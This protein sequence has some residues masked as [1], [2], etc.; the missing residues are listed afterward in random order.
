MKPV[1]VLSM[2]STNIKRLSKKCIC[3]FV[4]E[5]GKIKISFRDYIM[6]YASAS[7]CFTRY[8]CL[9]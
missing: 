3:V 9:G 1:S 8:F 5:E 7:F 6:I 2:D 4:Y